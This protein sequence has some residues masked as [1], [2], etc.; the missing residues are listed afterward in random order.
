[1]FEKLRYRFVVNVCIKKI[2]PHL[3]HRLR[4]LNLAGNGAQTPFLD[5]NDKTPRPA[6]LKI[7][8]LGSELTGAEI[9]VKYGN[10]AESIL[11]ELDI[12]KLTLID[13]WKSHY[14]GIDKKYRKGT[15]NKAYKRVVKL[16]R[17]MPNVEIMKMYSEYASRY[18]EDNSL[19]FVYIDA[20]HDYEFVLADIYNWS[21]KVKDGGI[22]SGHDSMNNKDV[23]DA[24]LHYCSDNK[25]KFYIDPPD[26]YFYKDNEVR[27]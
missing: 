25:I 9:G 13:I 3:Y 7:K 15:M 26:W 5:F 1:M 22:V 16:F 24:V 4:I 21:Q 17:D 14:D 10:N 6:I 8:E 20:N 23:F 2:T 18:V 19:D 27:Y 12:K 11:E